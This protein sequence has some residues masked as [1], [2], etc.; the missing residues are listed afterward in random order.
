MYWRWVAGP[1]AGNKVF[2]D[3]AYTN[4]ND[5]EPN[6]YSTGEWCGEYGH[7]V[8]GVWNDYPDYAS[9]IQGY[10]IEFSGFPDETMET[11]PVSLVS[12]F[13]WTD[14]DF[15]NIEQKIEDKLEDAEFN[16]HVTEEEIEE[17]ID[18]VITDAGI[19]N[20][21]YIIENKEINGNVLSFDIVVSI[22]EGQD[23]KT[24]T[25]HVD[26]EIEIENPA[27]SDNILV[28]ICML[29]VSLSGI[30]T[31]FILKKSKRI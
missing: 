19:E 3:G 23:M 1:E 22:G 16:E 14:Y 15:R 28:Y 9:D 17:I 5:G 12:T 4:F 21:T 13:K 11:E 2:E 30:A 24:S 18:E 7:G 6:N 25:I 8:G 20:T 10:Y 29:G 31:M 26:K 27:T